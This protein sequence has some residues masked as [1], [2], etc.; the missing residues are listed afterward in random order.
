MFGIVVVFALFFFVG[1]LVLPLLCCWCHCCGDYHCFM[2]GAVVVCAVLVLC[3]VGVS[4][5]GG[6]V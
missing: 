4:G 1:V 2:F 3:D 5:V 6:A